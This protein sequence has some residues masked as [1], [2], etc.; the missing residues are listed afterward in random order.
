MKLGAKNREL[1]DSL[2]ME[3]TNLVF[4]PSTPDTYPSRRAAGYLC[5]VG[6]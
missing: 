1:V 4:S 3:E 2:G 5:W 6:D